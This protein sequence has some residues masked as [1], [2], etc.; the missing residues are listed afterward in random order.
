MPLLFNLFNQ[1][2]KRYEIRLYGW[3]KVI[4]Y[5][6]VGACFSLGWLNSLGWGS[7]NGLP[8]CLKTSCLSDT[9]QFLDLYSLFLI[10][11][12]NIVCGTLYFQNFSVAGVL[13]QFK[14]ALH[15]GLLLHDKIGLIKLGFFSFYL[16][17]LILFQFQILWRLFVLQ[18]WV[19]SNAIFSI[20]ENR[21][22]ML[23]RVSFFLCV[24]FY[25]SLHEFTVCINGR[26]PFDHFDFFYH[27]EVNIQRR[28]ALVLCF[29]ETIL[30]NIAVML[31]VFFVHV[32]TLQI[33]LFLFLN[34]LLVLRVFFG[35]TDWFFGMIVI[36]FRW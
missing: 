32:Q 5:N 4:F 8:L 36:F 23:L 26:M 9:F 11:L 25:L 28:V 16:I 20:L 17:I 3:K 24:F 12:L 33:G 34:L 22:C 31:F 13:F 6:E 18:M 2:V 27:F 19:G 30:E 10:L 29:L 15:R 35:F 21:K 1:V 7:L 14:D